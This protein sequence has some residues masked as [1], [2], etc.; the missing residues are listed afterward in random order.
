MTLTGLLILSSGA[1]L[2]TLASIPTVNRMMKTWFYGAAYWLVSYAGII[3]ILGI[4]VNL[5]TGFAQSTPS[6][7]IPSMRGDL[8]ISY[9][10]AGLLVTVAGA[11]RMGASLAS[12]TLA[13]RYGSRHIIGWSTILTG[14]AMLLFGYSPNYLAAIGAFAL[15][16]VSTGGALTPMMG[17]LA[18]WF[19]MRNRGLAA[20]LAASG[21]SIAIVASGLLVP[22]L[23]D[24]NP[25]DGW[26]HTWYIFGLLVLAIGVICLIFLRD[27]PSDTSA[28]RPA[29]TGRAAAQR[30]YQGA[31]PLEV[32]KNPHVWLL[33]YLAF[34]SG[35]AHGVFTTF[36]GS[37]LSEEN[38]VSLATTG[39]L[40]LVV[41]VLSI[42]CGV[43]WGNISDR[44][45]R[46]QAFGISFFIQGVGFALFW[47]SPVMASFALG[48][49]LL[50]L[51][52]RAAFTLCAA[53]AGDRVQAQFASAAF[54][55]MSVGAGLGSSTSPLLAGSI[56]DTVGISWVFALG[57][58]ASMVGTTGAVLL[59]SPGVQR[60]EVLAEPGD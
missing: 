19:E 16:G 17:L 9:T 15:M 11:V 57:F 37:Y 59:R 46:G 45:G 13:P 18:P 49:V 36:F 56:A 2:I 39:H 53:A 4:L 24:H 31:W 44:M 7:T 35:G 22:P 26:R 58:G 3:L 10:Q 28:N 33:A 47:V 32:Y 34:C 6:L 27:R 54:A 40:F 1:F 48:S 8:G 25:A 21:G 50:G 52:L 42:I 29:P 51:T 14:G 41:G 5:A 12:G 30:S 60:Q 38:G 43:L 23:V 20:G 55:L